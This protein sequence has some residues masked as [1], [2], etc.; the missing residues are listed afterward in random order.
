[1][2]ESY[3][4]RIRVI[5][6]SLYALSQIWPRSL[7]KRSYQVIMRLFYLALLQMTFLVITDLSTNWYFHFRSTSFTTKVIYYLGHF[8][9]NW[10][11][12]SI[13]NRLDSGNHPV[14]YLNSVNSTWNWIAK[15]VEL[16]KS[17]EVI[18]NS[19]QFSGSK[20]SKIR[21]PTYA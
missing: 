6:G 8:R 1:M 19:N 7:I 15:I 3:H 14:R 18:P 16:R 13:I 21:F 12:L 17:F 20:S 9:S 2:A 5:S 11:K 10:I 4:I